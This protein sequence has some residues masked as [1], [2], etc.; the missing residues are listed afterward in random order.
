MK[1]TQDLKNAKTGTPKGFSREQAQQQPAATPGA[2][3][4]LALATGLEQTLLAQAGSVAELAQKTDL[5]ATAIAKPIA[6]FVG[7]VANGTL[8]MSKIAEQVESL[9]SGPSSLGVG[10]VDVSAPVL[11][12]LPEAKINQNFFSAPKRITGV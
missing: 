8:L 1:T 12:A 9:N 4:A 7:N 2:D 5:A 3:Q 10:N 6:E 11:P